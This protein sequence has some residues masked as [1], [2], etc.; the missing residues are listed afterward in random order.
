[1]PA[2]Q[3][4]N[5]PTTASSIGSQINNHFYQKKALIEAAKEQYFSQLASVESMPKNMGKKIKR[6][7]YLPLLDDANINDQGID[8]AGVTISYSNY[9]VRLQR[10]VETFAV[11]ADATAAAAAVN[12]VEASTAVKSGSATPWT[13]TFTKTV[14]NP[15]TAALADAVVAAVPGSMS[16]RGSGNLYGS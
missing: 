6:Y 5:P 4:N 1:M 8:A 11:E 13:V 7:H 12:A 16:I 2:Q 10:L 15:T 3:Y 9:E 14:L